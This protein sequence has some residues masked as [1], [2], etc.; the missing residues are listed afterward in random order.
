[1]EEMMEG[2]FL[3]V[4][5]GG[6]MTRLFQGAIQELIEMAIREGGYDPDTG[7]R[8]FGPGGVKGSP[9]SQAG[10]SST[11]WSITSSAG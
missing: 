1:M 9:A 6:F 8:L 2:G 4:G 3:P 11:E 5:E 7:R 10:R